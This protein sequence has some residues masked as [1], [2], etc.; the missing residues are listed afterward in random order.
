MHVFIQGV[1]VLNVL[2]PVELDGKIVGEVEVVNE[3]RFEQK[4]SYLA[5]GRLVQVLA[6]GRQACLDSKP[7]N[8]RIWLTLEDPR[9]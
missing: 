2:D 6:G 3:G 4:M 1:H 9:Q 7:E 5:E 8:N